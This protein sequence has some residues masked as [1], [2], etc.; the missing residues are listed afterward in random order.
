MADTHEEAKAT[1]PENM[2]NNLS[3]DE[4]Q[5]Q[6]TM[7]EDATTCTD[8]DQEF[9]VRENDPEFQGIWGN[10]DATV[11]HRLSVLEKKLEDICKHF[12][13][14]PSGPTNLE[15]M[16]N[17]ISV[18]ENKNAKLA[19]ENMALKLE[20]ADLKGFIVGKF[21]LSKIMLKIFIKKTKKKIL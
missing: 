15:K 12:M 1:L 19:D 21:L 5:D 7:N 17:K 10:T 9:G 6:D 14:G 16:T 11:D 8:Y 2:E 4:D 20:N 18:L 3:E 13:L